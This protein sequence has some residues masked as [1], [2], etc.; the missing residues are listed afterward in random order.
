MKISFFF[1]RYHLTVV[2]VVSPNKEYLKIQCGQLHIEK[3][4]K[5][6]LHAINLN[7]AE[8]SLAKF[9]RFQSDAV[10]ILVDSIKKKE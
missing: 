4:L 6:R 9:L 3:K 8:D 5:V 7:L 2:V 1:P 10:R